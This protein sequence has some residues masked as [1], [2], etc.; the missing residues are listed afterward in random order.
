MISIDYGSNE[1]VMPG[2][3]TGGMLGTGRSYDPSLR[4]PDCQI[5][6]QMN[7]AS[8]QCS[9]LAV[10]QYISDR[11]TGSELQLASVQAAIRMILWQLPFESPKLWRRGQWMSADT[12]TGQR[13][14]GIRNRRIDS[15][16]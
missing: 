13:A 11:R 9:P 7:M 16:L 14:A 3:G 2:N 8:M 4:F 1:L 5:S 12:F 15:L 6:A 10:A